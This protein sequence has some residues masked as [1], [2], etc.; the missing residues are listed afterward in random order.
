MF[1]YQGFRTLQHR[2]AIIL[3]VPESL[4]ISTGGSVELAFLQ[5]VLE[6]LLAVRRIDKHIHRVSCP[7]QIIRRCILGAPDFVLEVISPSTKRKDYTIK[8]A[9]YQNAGVREYWLVD[10]YQKVVLVYFF[11]DETYPVIYPIDG[12]IPVNIYEGKLVLSFARIGE[13]AK[14]A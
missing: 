3:Q 1:F 11:E 7:D 8:L 2:E 4:L 12:D 10:P 6:F 5:F 9:K 13:W 14:Q